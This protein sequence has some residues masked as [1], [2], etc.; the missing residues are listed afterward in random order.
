[1][2]TYKTHLIR[3]LFSPTTWIFIIWLHLPIL[4]GWIWTDNIYWLM[5]HIPTGIGGAITYFEKTYRFYLYDRNTQ[6]RVDWKNKQMEYSKDDKSALFTFNDIKQIVSMKRILPP[7]FYC[8]MLKNGDRFYISTL[9]LPGLKKE[10]RKY[11]KH[12]DK[13]LFFN[14]DRKPPILISKNKFI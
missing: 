8:I 11:E 10:L 5:F 1:M 3:I 6:L 9:I 14:H 13:T 4:W 12:I 2:K 7:F